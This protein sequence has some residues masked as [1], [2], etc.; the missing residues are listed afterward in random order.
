MIKRRN[1]GNT[2]VEVSEISLGCWALGGNSYGPVSSEEA[3][4][5]MKGALEGGI[6]FFDT[7]DIYGFGES[8]KRIGLFLKGT[9]RR[10]EVFIATKGGFNFESGPVRKDFSIPHLT[11]AL[12]QSLKRLGVERVD[13]YQLHL[14]AKDDLKK[15]ECLEFLAEAKRL[16]KTRFTG[17]SLYYPGDVQDWLASLEIDS[18]QFPYNLIEKGLERELEC[19]TRTGKALIVR[20]IFACGFL[21]GRYSPDSA[22]GKEDHRRAYSREQK[23]EIFGKMSELQVQNNWSDKDLFEN[24]MQLALKPRQVSSAL[25]GV[26]NAGQLE[27]D[28]KIYQKKV[29]AL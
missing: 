2:G 13:L 22:F 14:P 5:V 11:R 1:F 20:E 27:E 3:R 16:G 26:R 25:I 17:A 7:A 28:L 10:E 15:G 8:E 9:G 23:K 21:F 18:I 4:E 12:D 29:I 19:F 24:A 6:D